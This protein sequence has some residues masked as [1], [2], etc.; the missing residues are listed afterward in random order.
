M[1]FPIQIRLTEAAREVAELMYKA[2]ESLSRLREGQLQI[3]TAPKEAVYTE[4]NVVLYRYTPQVE[5]PFRFPLLISYALV[6]R[7]YMVDLQE[8]RSLVRGLLAHGIDVYLIDWG[9]PQRGDRWLTID[10]HVNG[11]INNCVDVIRKRHGLDQ[12][13]LLGICQGGTF[14]LCYTALHPDKIKNLIAMVAPVDFNV[15]DGLL[16]VWSGCSYEPQ[17]MDVDLM[18]DALGNV[19]GDFMNFGFLMLKP[20]QL[21]VEKYIGLADVLD[22][23]AKLINFLRME[24][25]IFDSPDQA[26]ET[27]RQFIRDFF[28]NNKLVKGEFE[29]GGRRVSLGKITMPVLN[30]YAEQ[31][32]LVPPASSMA[33]AQYVGTKDYTAL[34]FPVGHI[35]MYVS[36]KVQ[37]DLPPTIA[38]WLKARG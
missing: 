20:F 18:V 21:N 32:H 14:S 19:P 31:D 5:Q 37:R 11:Y 3:G 4:D 22:D 36:G 27:F 26:G 29:L 25:W 10:D 24:K 9:Y 23:E 33:L 6:N 38:G 8:D 15:C 1:S 35:G 12:I 30:L 2:T 34:S 28:Q 7:P 17:S 16:N 13:N